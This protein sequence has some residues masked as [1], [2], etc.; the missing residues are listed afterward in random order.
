MIRLRTW[1]PL[2]AVLVGVSAGCSATRNKLPDGMSGDPPSQSDGGSDGGEAADLAQDGTDGSQLGGSDPF[3]AVFNGVS[4]ANLKQRLQEMTGAA[5]ITKGGSTFITER[6]SQ[7]SKATFRTYWKEYMKGLG[8]TITD[9]SQLRVT[10][11]F[12]Q[13]DAHY[14]GETA[15]TNLEAVLPGKSADSIII[16]THYDTVGKPNA[17]AQ[18]PGAD[19]AASGLATQMEAARIFA[20]IPNRKNTVRFVACDY[21]EVD[22]T[23]FKGYFPGADAYLS[24]IQGLSKT[25]AFKILMVSDNDQTAWSCWNNGNGKVD[26]GDQ[27]GACY[28]AADGTAGPTNG[29]FRVAISSEDSSGNPIAAMYDAISSG[30]SA[31]VTKYGDGTIKPVFVHDDKKLTK[32]DV[33]GTDQVPFGRAGLPAYTTAEWGAN[34]HYDDTGGDLESTVDYDYLFKMSQLQITLQATLMGVDSSP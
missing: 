34:P 24:Y 20:A 9:D 11:G 7:T 26:Y 5:P 14:N 8:A 12:K 18:N 22:W 3:Q 16:I 6:W 23:S 31:V 10:L 33:E 29:L 25:Q 28:P 17:D 4:L 19:D 30:F 32:G 27:D 13:G 15:G 21:E 2:I 1:T